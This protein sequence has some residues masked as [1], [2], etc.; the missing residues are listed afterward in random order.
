MVAW[1]LIG[2]FSIGLPLLLAAVLTWW[3]AVRAARRVQG[4]A[5]AMEMAMAAVGVLVLSFGGLG[6][7]G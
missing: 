3:A 4:A 2:I 5:P 7:A 1:G 6:L